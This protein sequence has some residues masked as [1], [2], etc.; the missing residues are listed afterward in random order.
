MAILKSRNALGKLLMKLHYGEAKTWEKLPS[1]LHSQWRQR[2][3]RLLAA[4]G[5]KVNTALLPEKIPLYK[6]AEFYDTPLKALDL[7]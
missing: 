3:A 1:Y 5:G 6:R 4:N 2:A 7:T